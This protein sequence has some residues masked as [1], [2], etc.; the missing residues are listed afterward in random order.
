[1]NLSDI[2][3]PSFLKTLKTK[4]LYE[5]ADQIRSFLTESISK[6]GGH[7][8]SNLGT[9]E[10]IIALHYVF[11]SPKDA[12]IFDVGHQAYTHK[13]LTGRASA[14]DTLRQTDGLSGY[15]NYKESEH[16]I[17]ESGHAGTS[18]SALLG[19]LYA[20]HLKNEKGEGIAIIG[21]A[22]ITNGMAFEALNLLGSERKKRG[23]IIIN[24]NEMSI[25][26][27]VG[28]F[29]KALV[30]VRSMRLVF[31]IKRFWELVLP[32][33]ILNFL[34]RVK[35]GL[36]GFLQRQ[37]IFEDLGYMYIGPLD[38][39][40]IKGLI[41]NLKRVEKVKKSV[42]IHIITEKGKG[43]KEAENDKVGTFH[44]VS[45]ASA[46]QK[47]GISWSALIS[48][49]LDK[50][51]DELKTFVVMP[52][53]TVGAQFIE[54]AHKYPDRYLDVG[55]AEEHATT[56][57]ASLAHQ[58]IPVFLPLYSTFAQ[59]AFDQ[60]LNDISRS[61]H[62]VVFG[63]D[64]AGIVGEDGSTHQGLFDVSMFYVM[65][66]MV[67]TMPYDAKE[68]ASLL[69]YGFTKQK[70]PFVIRYPRGMVLF[71]PLS[72]DLVFE[73]IEPTWT[74]LEHGTK[75]HLIGYGPS[76]DLLIAVK[77][78]MKLDAS[79]INAR[80]IKPMDETMLHQLC[81]TGQPIFVYEEASNTGSLYPQILKFMAKHRYHN[82]IMDASITDTIVEHG[83]YKDMLRKLD[84]DEV[85]IIKKLE[86]LI[87][88]T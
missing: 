33:F 79:V 51:Q 61:D 23:I 28:A 30:R 64:R 82:R 15:I 31:K 42:V 71:D 17:W 77:Q 13:I 69:K 6:T 67:I 21:D 34:S 41:Y 44:G 48:L 14:F 38:G 24:D 76:L 56:M 27:S 86:G 55:I 37:N 52:A 62:H 74:K 39:H 60:L 29:S 63:I 75:L 57:A 50:L 78:K 9:I 18:L 25:S 84:M 1:M 70:H 53:M 12:F 32:R 7:L 87:R 36:R 66:N 16:D 83:H 2:K 40:N 46:K 10:L 4:E 72:E 20:K 11:N 80:F 35:R 65:P 88:E 47:T 85:G 22:S 26:K 49:S 59:R 73:E 68:A 8:S 43:H 5:L 81:K 58:G 19:V 3:D 45:K 54:F